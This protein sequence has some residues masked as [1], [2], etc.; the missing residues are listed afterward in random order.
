[1]VSRRGGW[2]VLEP[3]KQHLDYGR[4]DIGWY[5]LGITPSFFEATN[6]TNVVD[7]F[8][9]GQLIDYDTAQ[10]MLETHWKTWYTEDDFAAISKAGLNFVR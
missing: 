5:E 10:A 6:N 3:C 8:T 7:E 1:M 2:F 4:P 9:L